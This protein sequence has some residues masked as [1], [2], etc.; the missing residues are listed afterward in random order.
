LSEGDEAGADKVDK[1]S[2]E[3]EGE[4]SA[5]DEDGDEGE[6]DDQEEE[7]DLFAQLDEEEKDAL[8][9]NTASVYVILE[10]VHSCY[11]YAW[12]HRS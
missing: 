8:L 4:D 5:E 2:G 12:C 10:K 7:E 6:E 3:G 9:E 1:E 11:A